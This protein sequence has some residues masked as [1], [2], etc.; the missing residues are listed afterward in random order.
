MDRKA[1]FVAMDPSG[2]VPV[3]GAA[4]AVWV[5]GADEHGW[6]LDALSTGAPER[7][8]GYDSRLDAM[9][10]IETK[11][12]LPASIGRA[13]GIPLTSLLRLA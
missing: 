10:C 2:A 8:V 1:S 7:R 6:A 13:L 11:A 4:L 9:V 3:C 5:V 12:R